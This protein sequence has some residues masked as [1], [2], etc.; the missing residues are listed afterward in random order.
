MGYGFSRSFYGSFRWAMG[1]VM[2]IFAPGVYQVGQIEF[3]LVVRANGY[4]WELIFG[5]TEFP[6]WSNVCY[7]R[8]VE[9]HAV[10]FR[11]ESSHASFDRMSGV[12][13]GSDGFFV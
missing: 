7:C 6:N 8:F 3:A 10:L 4:Q 9:D 11:N 12:L 13:L 2:L 5:W 1:Y